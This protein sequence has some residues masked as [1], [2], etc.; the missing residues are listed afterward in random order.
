MAVPGALSQVLTQQLGNTMCRPF[1]RQ[2]PGVQQ[3][4]L[5]STSCGAVTA[6]LQVICVTR[7]YTAAL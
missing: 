5:P 1:I 2:Q 6:G 3:E 4:R 7:C